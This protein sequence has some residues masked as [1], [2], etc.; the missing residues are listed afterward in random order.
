MDSTKKW[1]TD[2]IKS[3]RN[4]T[5]SAPTLPLTD[6]L[7]PDLVREIIQEI[8]LTFRE[9]IDTP[10]TTLCV[11][12]GQVFS[13]DHSCREAVARLLAFR[14]AKG[15]RPCS[16][17]TNPYCRARQR[18]PEKLFQILVNEL[19]GGCNEACPISGS[20]TAVGSSR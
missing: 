12:L 6:L 17:D 7:A 11:F 1:I 8:D 10:F 16:P 9:R 13:E 18:L 3:F 2:Q 19:A 4:G 5:D 15:Q 14:I 20:F